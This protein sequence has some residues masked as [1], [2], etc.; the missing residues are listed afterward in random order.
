MILSAC[1][2]SDTKLSKQIIGSWSYTTG[3][4]TGIAISPDG[5]WISTFSPTMHTAG[6][7]QITNGF[8]FYT[9][10]EDTVNRHPRIG[11]VEQYKIVHLDEHVIVYTA[12]G[13]NYTLS[14]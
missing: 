7:W 12:K 4:G 14:R 2:P 10:T 13:K 9:T 8:I 5:S 11:A 3:Q 1:S 6:T